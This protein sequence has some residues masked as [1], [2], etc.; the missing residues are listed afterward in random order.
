M[1][2]LLTA[3]RAGA[4]REVPAL[5]LGLDAAG[6]KAA[7]AELKELRKEVRGWDWQRQDRIRKALHVAGAGCH[8]GAAGCATWIGG[9]DLRGWSRS[10]YPLILTALGDRDPAWLGDLAQRLAAKSLNSDAEFTFIS[11]LARMAG[12]PVP[13]T[14]SVVEGWVERIS[15]ARWPGRSGRTPLIGIL[16]SDPHV[17]VLAP[18]LF[19]MAELPGQVSWYETADSTD[20]WPGALRT[21]AEEGVLDRSR[22]AERCVTRLVRGGKTGDQRF[23]LTVL[24]QVGITEDEERERLRDWMGMAADGISV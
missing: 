21:L 6:R 13:V 23:F 1:S 3:V 18:R 8:T 20:H 5:V 11:E 7:L 10:P 22:L 14:D 24:Q 4:H 17:A 16:R 19:E 2:D 12:G 15:T 9:R